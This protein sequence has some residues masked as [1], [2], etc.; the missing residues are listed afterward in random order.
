MNEETA[1]TAAGTVKAAALHHL[2]NVHYS[3]GRYE[4][5]VKKYEES[6][7]LKK[8]LGDK[9]GIASTLGQLGRIFQAQGNYKEALRNYLIAFTIFHELK[10]PYEELA[11][12]DLATLK[13]ELGDELFNG[14]FEEITKN[15]Q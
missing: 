13:E 10:L 11:K 8:E 12:R 15:E 7:Q 2:G 14:Y 3:Q 1:K 9:R 5:A 4:D 6:L